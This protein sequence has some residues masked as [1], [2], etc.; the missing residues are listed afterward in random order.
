MNRIEV[1]IKIRKWS[2]SLIRDRW[3][4]L[5]NCYWNSMVKKEIL[6]LEEK[7]DK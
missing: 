5:K 7:L 4:N 1:K 3:G 6:K 2:N